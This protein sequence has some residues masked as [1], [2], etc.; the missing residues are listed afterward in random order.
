MSVEACDKVC[1][2]G[3]YNMGAAEAERLTREGPCVDW[4]TQGSV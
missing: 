4:W 2:V 3:I 1:T